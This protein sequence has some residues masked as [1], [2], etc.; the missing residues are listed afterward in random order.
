MT[1]SD[2]RP[3]ATHSLA[4]PVA[5]GMLVINLRAEADPD[6]LKAEVESAMGALPV[7]TAGVEVLAAFR[8]GRPTP[9]HRLAGSP[10]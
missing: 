3:Q 9:T 5:K 10:D 2:G 1:R 8:P 4:S 7:K 6:V